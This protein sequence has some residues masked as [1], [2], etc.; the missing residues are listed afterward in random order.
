MMNSQ[1]GNGEHEVVEYDVDNTEF[2]NRTDPIYSIKPDF[3]TQW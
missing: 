3:I 1:L 2:N